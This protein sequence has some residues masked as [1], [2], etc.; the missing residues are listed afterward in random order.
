MTTSRV[1]DSARGQRPNS[2]TAQKFVDA[3]RALAIVAVLVT[4]AG[5]AQQVDDEQTFNGLT[6]D[7]LQS[8]VLDRAIIPGQGVSSA[9][10]GFDFPTVERSLGQ[11]DEVDTSGVRK[12]VQEW[13]YKMDD[14]TLLVVSGE[15][16]VDAINLIGSPRSSF[17]TIDGVTFGMNPAGVA[18][19]YGPTGDVDDETISYEAIGIAF[20]FEDHG[21]AEIRV[22]RPKR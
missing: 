20:R 15:D 17:M 7:V 9:A 2:T 16:V 6:A 5:H 8:V 14:G 21:L 19:V 3:T 1:I 22:T 18:A 12:Q 4:G 13:R 11:P 10:I